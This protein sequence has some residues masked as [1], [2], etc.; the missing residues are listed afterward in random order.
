MEIILLRHGKPKVVLRGNLNTKDL[1]Q[2]VFDYEQS[3]IQEPP[4]EKLK[5]QFTNHYA[6][7][8]DLVRSAE[9]AKKLSLAPVSDALFRE[10]DIPHFD[11]IPLKLPVTAWIIL[12]RVMWLFGFSKNGE[13]FAQAK[14]RSRQAAEK[15]ISLAE[16]NEKIIVVGHGL[17]N[18]LIGK[19]LLKKGW[20]ESERAGKRFWEFRRYTVNHLEV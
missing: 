1:K 2:L 4:S 10:T 7:C 8:S 17:M 11:N 19:Q 3:G 5:T 12:L 14:N 16:E 18:H 15:L 20:L 9:S 6:V 13:S